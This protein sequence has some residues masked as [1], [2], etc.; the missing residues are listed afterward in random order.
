MEGFL[1]YRLEARGPARAAFT[2]AAQS[3]RQMR[4]WDCYALA[5]QDLAALAYE[6]KNYT[7]ALFAFG[8]ALRQLPPEL[9]PKLAADIW[10]NYGSM[11]GRVGLF[12]SSQHSYA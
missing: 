10:A 7:V 8:D 1:E 3:C 4:D 11:Q 12:G 6:N 9:D 5:N 2:D